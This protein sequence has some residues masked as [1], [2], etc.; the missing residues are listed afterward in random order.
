MRS[1]TKFVGGVV[2]QEVT[3][4]EAMDNESTTIAQLKMYRNGVVALLWLPDIFV[5]PA[6]PMPDVLREVIVAKLRFHAD[7]I[8]SREMDAQLK[9]LAGPHP[10]ES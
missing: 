2:R 5:N 10:G 6:L 9:E 4:D 3:A 7:K 1:K 8:E